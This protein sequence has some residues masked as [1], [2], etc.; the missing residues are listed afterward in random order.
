[1][2]LGLGVVLPL[3]VLEAAL[4]LMGMVLGVLFVVCF[5]FLYVFLCASLGF[6]VDVLGAGAAFVTLLAWAGGIPTWPHCRD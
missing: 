4:S 6:V 3:A 5:G 1:M 2:G